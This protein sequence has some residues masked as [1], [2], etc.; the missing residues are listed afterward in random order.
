MLNVNINKNTLVRSSGSTLDPCIQLVSYHTNPSTT[1]SSS[2]LDEI[3]PTKRSASLKRQNKPAAI[4]IMYN[5]QQNDEN[6]NEI[7]SPWSG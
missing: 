5:N 7:Y 3:N 4:I 2:S 1:L 6:D